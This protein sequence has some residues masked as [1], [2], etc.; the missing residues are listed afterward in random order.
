[1]KSLPPSSLS[2]CNARQADQWDTSI[3]LCWEAK[4]V[5]CFQQSTG[6][7]ALYVGVPV[8][9]DMTLRKA[10]TFFF[11]HKNSRE[12]ALFAKALDYRS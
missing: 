1:M 4:K 8:L 11:F 6:H 3:F 5:G 2:L 10:A 9:G 7:Q 12:I